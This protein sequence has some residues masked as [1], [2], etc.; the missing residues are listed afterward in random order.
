MYLCDKKISYCY[1]YNSDRILM[2]ER[3]KRRFQLFEKGIFIKA[4]LPYRK[5]TSAKKKKNVIIINLVR[6][7]AIPQFPPLELSIT[8]K[9]FCV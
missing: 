8:R 6:Q 4:T 5:E 9:Q 3:L 1:S 7:S 2:P